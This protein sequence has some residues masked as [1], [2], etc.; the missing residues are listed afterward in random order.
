MNASIGSVTHAI[1]LVRHWW[2]AALPLAL[3]ACGAA[4]QD[5]A[6]PTFTRDAAGLYPLTVRVEGAAP[7]TSINGVQAVTSVGS[8]PM[9][10]AG[11]GEW[12]AQVPVAACVNGF[13]VQYEASWT[14]LLAGN[15]AR[16][17]RAGVRQK[18]L[19]G[20][21]Q[22]GCS[23]Q[24]GR[25]FVVDSTADLVDANP[26][27]GVCAAAA[28]GGPCT[29]RAAVMEANALRGQDRIELGNATYTLTRVGDDDTATSGDLDILDEVAIVGTG[30]TILSAGS[31]GDR[32]FDVAPTGERVDLELRNLVVRDG[33]PEGIGG[34]IR[35]RGHLQLHAVSVR[36]N[37]ARGAGGG[38]ANDGGFV[39]LYDSE[40]HDNEVVNAAAAQ[41]GGL[42]SAGASAS[43]VIRSSSV[44]SNQSGQHG[45]GLLIIEGRLDVRD[46]T[47]ADNRTD[48]YGA[49]V[50]LNGAVRGRLRNVTITGNQADFNP[51][52]IGDG[53][54]VHRAS[55]PGSLRIANSVIAENTAVSGRDCDSPIT[56]E[57][58]NFF[59]T[60]DGCSGLAASDLAGTDAS[61]LDPKLGPLL[62]VGNTR[63]RTPQTGSPLLDAGSPDALN[64]ERTP[65]CT[66]I[67]QRGV[68]RP[69][70]PLIDGRARCDIGAI[71]RQ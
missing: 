42:Q 14:L 47:I 53:G 36:S 21:P 70:G 6:P 57:G 15:I 34:G 52:G 28:F 17:P 29:L 16:E 67:D 63:S 20:E 32:V 61:P 41:G 58:Y 45:G 54:G 37:V 18:W 66:H 2:L 9:A 64:D 10:P 71:E 62:A 27:D 4:V 68:E 11:G 12:S 56:S 39:E 33:R 60:A 8:F 22:P 7:G 13:D 43:V 24:F 44:T 1:S 65:R 3:A 50:F 69:L 35:N 55:G 48:V 25:R 31:I 49:G 19:T 46:T 38:I 59:G 5:R 30:S 26:G 23:T 40:L 51:S